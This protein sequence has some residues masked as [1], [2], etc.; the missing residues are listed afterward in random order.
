MTR[1]TDL[2]LLLTGLAMAILLAGCSSGQVRGEA[3]FAQVMNWSIEGQ[4]LTA[5]LRL[6]NVNDEPLA[7][8]ALALRVVLQ[9]QEVLIDHRQAVDL[10]IPAGGFERVELQ[11]DATPGGTALLQAL[12]EKTLNSLPYRLDGN[13]ES[14]DEGVLEFSR[15]G[16]IYT[17]P[18]R[19]GQFR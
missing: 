11:L 5:S 13:V 17:V 15:E 10:D 8:N 2:K 19:P 4:N 1:M 18:G 16:F 6:R 12:E 9:E 14:P 7:V 3:P